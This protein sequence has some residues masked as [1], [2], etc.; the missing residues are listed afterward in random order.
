MLA[1]IFIYTIYQKKNLTKSFFIYSALAFTSIST[2]IFFIV[3]PAM[4]VTPLQVIKNMTDAAINSGAGEYLSVVYAERHPYLF[5]LVVILFKFSPLTLFLLLL[6]LIKVTHRKDKVAFFL[7]LSV[8]IQ[9]ILL[10]ASEQKIERYILACMP[11]MF[12]LV[13]IV[14]A[15]FPASTQKVAVVVMIVTSVITFRNYHP[16]YSSYYSGMFGGPLS[17]Y[18]VGIYDDNGE[19]FARVAQYLNAKGRDTRVFVP[20][21]VESFSPYFKGKLETQLMTDEGYF[22]VSKDA[23]RPRA[24]YGINCPIVD[25]VVI[26]NYLEAVTIFKCI[27]PDPAT[28]KELEEI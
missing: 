10:S 16:L 11:A 12:L 5:Y 25:Q 6:A 20:Y 9:L 17:A 28:L 8:I 19:F 27:K 7:I 2:L 23:R 26:N 1:L 4:W 15:S 22:V 3:F 24:T 18:K 13:A 21:N 14:L